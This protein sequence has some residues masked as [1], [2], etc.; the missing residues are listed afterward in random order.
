MTILCA[1]I[2][3]DLLIRLREMLDRAARAD[4]AVGYFFVSGFAQVAD[5]ISR[6]RKTRILW[7]GPT[8]PRWKQWPAACTRPGRSKPSWTPNAWSPAANAGTSPTCPR[9]TKPRTQWSRCANV[10]SPREA[11]KF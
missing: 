3:P 8:G 1:T 7:A 4:I 10:V 11:K 6:L 9:R 5:E 2:D